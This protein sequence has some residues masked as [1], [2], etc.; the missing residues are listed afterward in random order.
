MIQEIQDRGPR[1]TFD[2]YNVMLALMCDENRKDNEAEDGKSF[3]NDE[4]MIANTPSSRQ[5]YS[6]WFTK[7]LE[8]MEDED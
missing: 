3:I 1:F 7:L 2:E 6:E 8:L 4:I 5:N